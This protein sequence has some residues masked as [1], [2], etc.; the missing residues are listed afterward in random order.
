MRSIRCVLQLAFVTM[1]AACGTGDAADNSKAAGTSMERMASSRIN[2]LIELHES[3]QPLLD[4]QETAIMKA[5]NLIKL[6]LN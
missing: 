2:A 6:G 1:I 4:H 3:D 5:E